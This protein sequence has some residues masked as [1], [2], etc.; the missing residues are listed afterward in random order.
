MRYKLVM[1]IAFIISLLFVNKVNA[2]FNEFPLIGKIIYLDAG[3]GGKAFP[4]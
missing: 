4:K 1:F 2:N 3:H